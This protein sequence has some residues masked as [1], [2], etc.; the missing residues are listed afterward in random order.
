MNA[1]NLSLV[2]FDLGEHETSRRAARWLNERYPGRMRN[3]WGSSFDTVRALRALPLGDAAR[4]VCDVVIV[5]GS[6]DWRIALPDLANMC[7]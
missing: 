6:H 5:D 3:V 2:E 1:N 4:P 7:E